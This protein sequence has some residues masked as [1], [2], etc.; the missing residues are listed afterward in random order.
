MSA[1]DPGSA[2]RLRRRLAFAFVVIPQEV[3]VLAPYPHS[4]L[5]CD[6]VILAPIETCHLHRKYHHWNGNTVSIKK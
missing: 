3:P 1:T 5:V 2:I 4:I 6:S